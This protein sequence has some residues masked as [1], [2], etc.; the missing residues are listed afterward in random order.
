M[1]Y[2]LEAIER[3]ALLREAGWEAKTRGMFGEMRDAFSGAVQACE[4][5]PTPRSTTAKRALANSLRGR[6]VALEQQ[7]NRVAASRDVV[8]ALELL[9]EPDLA[10]APG[11]QRL[12]HMCVTLQGHL[13]MCPSATLRHYAMALNIARADESLEIDAAPSGHLLIQGSGKL[14]V[15]SALCNVACAELRLGHF[16]QAEE[17]FAQVIA[18]PACGLATSANANH[19]MGNIARIQFKWSKAA[20]HW[21]EALRITREAG[22]IHQEASLLAV[23]GRYQQVAQELQDRP[24][25]TAELAD[26]LRRVGRPFDGNCG[27]CMDDD[28]QFGEGVFVLESCLHAFHRSCIERFWRSRSDTLLAVLFGASCP[29][30]NQ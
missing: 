3:A 30:C 7:N 15:A 2:E 28:V 10:A 11:I 1:D 9:A 13:S 29:K 19:E 22:N 5:I 8:R 12:Q 26:A 21:Q 6:A 25:V 20:G 14:S 24:S 16:E 18:N 27:I 4:S 17:H 23:F